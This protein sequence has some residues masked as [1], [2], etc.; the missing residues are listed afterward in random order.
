[1]EEA[2]FKV[3]HVY[4]LTETYGPAVICAWQQEWDSLPIKEQA[5]KKASQGVKYHVLHDLSVMNPKTM[6]P[7]P[8]DGKTMGEVMFRGNIV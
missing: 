4:G 1:M 6:T 3:T 8:R 2:G 7:V 5:S